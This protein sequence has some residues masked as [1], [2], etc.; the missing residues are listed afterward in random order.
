MIKDLIVTLA[1]GTQR[2]PARHYALSLAE[3]F[4]AHI[5]GMALHY[6]HP[7]PSTVLGQLPAELVA[8]ATREHHNAVEAAVEQFDAAARRSRVSADHIIEKVLARDAPAA[9]A[10]AARRFGTS[11][12][13]QSDPDG[14]DNNRLIQALLFDSGRPLNIV[15]YIQRAGLKLDRVVCCWDGSRPAARAIDDALP[16]LTRARAVDLF[17]VI[18]EKTK[19]DQREIRGVRMGRHLARHDVKV[20]VKTTVAPDI[21]VASAILAYVADSA[22]SMIVMGGFGQSRLREFILGGATRGILASM[23]VP[24]LMSH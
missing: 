13:M 18:N 24:I 22:A 21:D 15:P 11:V 8:K 4:E 14:A 23:T 1:V 7:I 10:N 17:I 9:L 5:T 19:S 16:F 3:A 12:I 6:E 2:D 20:E